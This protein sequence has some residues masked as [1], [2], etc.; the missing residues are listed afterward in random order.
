MAPHLWPTKHYVF[1][2]FADTGVESSI[3]YH[4]RQV[5]H[6]SFNLFRRIFTPAAPRKPANCCHDP[7][8]GKGS[9]T[10]ASPASAP[11]ASAEGRRHSFIVDQGP[12]EPGREPGSNRGDAWIVAADCLDRSG[13]VLYRSRDCR[14]AGDSNDSDL[15]G[16]NSSLASFCPSTSRARRERLDLRGPRE[17]PLGRITLS[18]GHAREDINA[19]AGPP[20]FSRLRSGSIVPA[21]DAARRPP[22]TSPRPLSDS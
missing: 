18:V 11:T 13:N 14:S 19:A 20:A 8:G 5:R 22:G 16:L 7:G 15:A 4:P 2:T 21:K 6:E 17:L 1:L 9:C 12:A 10:T 3:K